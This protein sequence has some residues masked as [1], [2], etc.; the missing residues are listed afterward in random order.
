MAEAP[1]IGP[2]PEMELA[3]LKAI[4]RSH[5][6]CLKHLF[7]AKNDKLKNYWGS[8]TNHWQAEMDLLLAH[9]NP[10]QAAE[11]LPDLI[12]QFNDHI[13]VLHKEQPIIAHDLG[14][15]FNVILETLLLEPILR[16]EVKASMKINNGSDE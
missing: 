4:M 8:A 10:M 14:Y 3:A 2:N 11:T 12:R 5:R 6:A 1:H 9:G 15:R 7:N 16:K 13:T